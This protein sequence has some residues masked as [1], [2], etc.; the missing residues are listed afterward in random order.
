[1]NPKDR[2]LSRM[3]VLAQ[4]Y[5]GFILSKEIIAIY[6][7][8]LSSLG[9]DRAS[10]AIEAI[11]KNRRSRDPFPSI[12]DIRDVI[13]PKIDPRLQAADVASRIMSAVPKFG[14]GRYQSGDG[15]KELHA[16]VKEHIGELGWEVVKVMGG[17]FRVCEQLED[18][19]TGT[20]RAQVRE[21]AESTY[22]RAEAGLL[23]QLPALPA[24]RGKDSEPKQ[25]GSVLQALLP[26]NFKAT[27]GSK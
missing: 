17:W 11:I 18:T 2:F 24:P 8:E 1:M 4:L 7:Q 13:E 15:L 12:A 26:N 22:R 21:L 16:K 27:D 5:P 10:F 23:N 19:D 3:A 6:D 9:Y 20:F 14:S 25:L